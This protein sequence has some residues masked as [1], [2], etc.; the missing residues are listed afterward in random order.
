MIP[1]AYDSVGGDEISRAWKS[2]FSVVD[3]VHVQVGL[4]LRLGV[5]DA[6]F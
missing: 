4:T 2:R 1:L 6:L 3:D 5:S